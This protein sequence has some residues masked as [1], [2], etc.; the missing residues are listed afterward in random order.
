M[1]VWDTPALIPH[2]LT[3]DPL[4]VIDAGPGLFYHLERGTEP[5]LLLWMA[6]HSMLSYILRV[7]RVPVA[8][9]ESVRRGHRGQEL[10][11]VL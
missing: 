3:A 5:S 1:C 8:L 6:G 11:S 2:R 4:A 7:I 10:C 9:P